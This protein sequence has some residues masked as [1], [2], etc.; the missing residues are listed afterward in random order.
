MLVL[1]R[2]DS[3]GG[4]GA[5]ETGRGERELRLA[6]HRW[7]KA[8]DWRVAR[9]SGSKVVT[10]EA[11]RSAA[12]EGLGCR[13]R[14]R[15][16]PSFEDHAGATRVSVWSRRGGSSSPRGALTRSHGGDGATR[17]GRTARCSRRHV[18]ASRSL[19]GV[20][21]GTLSRG[22]RVSRRSE[23]DGELRLVANQARRGPM[24]VRSCPGS[25]ETADAFQLSRRSA[26]AGA[27]QTQ[28]RTTRRGEERREAKGDSG[29]PPVEHR[30]RGVDRDGLGRR[31]RPDGHFGD[32]RADVT[33]APLIER[34]AP[35]HRPR[36]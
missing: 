36:P 8:P 14:C 6:A 5:E 12:Q 27:E 33:D 34:D 21:W 28:V 17:N 35:G 13:G 3:S 24:H 10:P 15:S 1:D 30:S 11:A 18:V 23:E 16:R 2:L 31:V 9:D 32:P 25:V 20:I 19:L 26:H 4:S 29:Q 22:T 7:G